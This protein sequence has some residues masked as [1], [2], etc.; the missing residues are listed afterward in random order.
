MIE[1]LVLLILI[2]WFFGIIQ[3]PYI[4]TTLFVFFGH[5]IT[6]HDLLLFFL[7]CWVVSILPRPFREI[8]GVLGILW[9]LSIVG[10]LAISG[11][12]NILVLAIIIGVLLSIFTT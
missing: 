9:V 2:L 3:I 10:I 12:A 4:N 6:L 7:F 11:L 8:A 5:P 1:A